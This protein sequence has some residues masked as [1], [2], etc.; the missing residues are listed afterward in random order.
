MAE[1]LA[2]QRAAEVLDTAAK[3]AFHSKR[4]ALAVA[5]LRLA[6]GAPGHGDAS[7]PLPELLHVSDAVDLLCRAE[8]EVLTS[9][10]GHSVGRM[11]SLK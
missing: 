2:L 11:C 5:D 6:G 1:R 10:V 3:Y 9:E 8:T 4:A 7:S